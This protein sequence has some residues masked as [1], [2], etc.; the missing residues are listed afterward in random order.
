MREKLLRL[1]NLLRASLLRLEVLEVQEAS[2]Y[3]GEALEELSEMNK[4]LE[5]LLK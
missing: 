3:L 4:E 5:E 2:D 1:E